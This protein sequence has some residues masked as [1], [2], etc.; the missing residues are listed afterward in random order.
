MFG[1]V[2]RASARSTTAAVCI[3]G[4]TIVLAGSMCAAF[5][6][7]KPGSLDLM[8]HGMCFLWAPSLL[9]ANAGADLLIACS[10]VVIAAAL[11][12]LFSRKRLPFGWMFVAFAAFIF[13]CA[14]THLMEIVTL[15]SPA[16]WL[17][18]GMKFAT[19]AA[20]ALTAV[21]APRAVRRITAL[22]HEAE[23]VERYR[24]ESLSAT[25]KLEEQ[26]IERGVHLLQA[27]SV[28]ER[29]LTHNVAQLE[30]IR[31]RPMVCED[32][33][34]PR[35]EALSHDAGI[36]LVKIHAATD[37]LAQIEALIE[38]ARSNALQQCIQT[39]SPQ[40][41]C[42]PA[43]VE[44]QAVSATH[45]D[46][47]DCIARCTQDSDGPVKAAALS[48]LVRR[49]AELERCVGER[50]IEIE[51]FSA[52][53]ATRL[54]AI[55]R[56]CVD[57]ESYAFALRKDDERQRAYAEQLAALH[58]IA[59]ATTARGKDQIESAL[60][61][62]LNY[63]NL[64][65]AYLGIIDRVA[66]EVVIAN[67]L[68]RGAE[69]I[70]AAGARFPLA[71]TIFHSS[72][73]HSSLDPQEKVAIVVDDVEKLATPPLQSGWKSYIAV[74]LYIDGRPYG[75][76]G[77]TS[78]ERRVKP[79]TQTD[80][81]FFSVAAELITAAVERRLKNEQLA[82]SE[83]QYRALTQ[84]MPQLVWI[85]NANGSL[86]FVNERWL[87][88][89]GLSFEE[90]CAIGIDAL[91]PGVPEIPGVADGSQSA[92]SGA[93]LR[94]EFETRIRRHDGQLRWHLVRAVCFG[95]DAVRD[96]WIVTGTDIEERK[97]SETLNSEAYAAAL[98]ATES[99]SRFLATMS[100]EIR[101]PM[102]GIVGMAELLMLTAL[103]DE[104]REYTQVMRDSGQSLLRV[105]NDILDYS[106]IEAGKVDVEIVDF[107]VPRQVHSVVELLQSQ[108][109]AK[110]VALSTSIDPDLPGDVLGDPGRIRQILLNLMGNSLKFTASG[111]RVAIALTAGAT[112][113]G[114]IAVRFTVSD[115]GIGIPS[116]TVDRLFQPFT[117]GD[118]STTRQY[119]GTGLGLS[120]SA[121]LVALMGGTIGVESVVGQ[122]SSFW[123]EVPFE[124]S[125]PHDRSLGAGPAQSAPFSAAPAM[126]PERILVVD[127]N[128]VN[129]LLAAKQLSRLGF[130]IE[131][132][133]SGE[134][135]IEA[136]E[137][138][139]FDLIFMDCQ[140]PDMDGFETTG[141]LRR[142]ERPGVKHIPIVAMT[143]DARSE[144]RDRCLQS[145][146]DDYLSK[147]ATLG[148][149][150]ALIDR[151]L[152]AGERRRLNREIVPDAVRVPTVGLALLFDIFDGDGAAVEQFLE[153]AITAIRADLRQIDQ[154]VAAHDCDRVLEAAHR[155]KGTSG[156]IRCARLVDLGS[157]LQTAASS[158]SWGI[159]PALLI[160]LREAV[161]TVGE[162]IDTYAARNGRAQIAAR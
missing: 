11:L 73:D 157:A 125:S 85:V 61:L 108:Y 52:E 96:R 118:A 98:A 21:A 41:H 7:S 39:E 101:T 25:A 95:D 65:W 76:I 37:E 19:V 123:F 71:A 129:T 64:D 117:Q 103:S 13:A 20:S 57:L 140:M 10:Y 18:T 110:N 89:T 106:K 127:D 78:H 132:V 80:I 114:K 29:A 66:G 24:F 48:E 36:A 16:Y 116:Q 130:E 55:C 102:N 112:V 74:P 158:E 40:L 23:L 72:L 69:L 2:S 150:E 9:W 134:A 34:V 120:I 133:A 94:T 30:E 135:C 63:F 156:S 88:F 160:K 4:A 113:A 43:T 146:M 22:M 75:V 53:L 152:P 15:W 32:P 115:T 31:S 35:S 87:E 59:S 128:D 62:G 161:K 104:Q 92:A 17:S 60:R 131:T 14:G 145:G 56:E 8:P 12:R 79:F 44:G 51:R 119:G 126:R 111:G 137:R 82:T 154:A 46:Y 49:N 70:V 121:Q 162:D 141:E 143:A 45:F 93:A 100:H 86:A 151:W 47:A 136:T 107:N 54:Q 26:T 90:S 6:L 97:L 148:A 5:A 1:T 149:L 68:G 77:F 144:D 138:E 33:V 159:A 3:V 99:K 84:A 27:N 58:A 109:R 83:A 122:G 155:L 124:R 42:E 50:M 153:A 91:V 38:C 28:L 67:S 147:P 81:E 142:R 105:L 139:R